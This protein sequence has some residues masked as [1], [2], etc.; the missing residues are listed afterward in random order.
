MIKYGDIVKVR[1]GKNG[2]DLIIHLPDDTAETVLK[3]H[4]RNV[5]IRLDDGR[6]ITVEQ[7]RKIYAT[8]NDI[9]FYLGYLP[10]ELKEEM[11]YYY[12]V[13]TKKEEFLSGD[14]IFSLSDCSVDT[15]RD[16]INF[17]LC[18]ALENDVPLSDCGVN[19]TDDINC[20]LYMCLKNRKCCVCGLY[21]EIHHVDAIGMGNDRRRV[22]DSRY[23]KM[24]LCRKHHTIA[25]QR[26]ME[27]FE[28][29]YKVYGIIYTE[30]METG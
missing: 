9:A 21:G 27:A 23:R 1:S 28:Q 8:L 17:I 15:A 29:M 3:K 2:S 13:K 11:K 12:I 26:G 24:C 5:E 18:F 16:F 19:R 30:D 7:R 4:I 22:D 6:H 20:Y 14:R 10:E 25:H